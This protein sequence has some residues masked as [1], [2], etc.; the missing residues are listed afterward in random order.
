MTDG[1]L[2]DAALDVLFQVA[3]VGLG[4]L[5]A[6]KRYVR[7]NE[8]LAGLNGLPVADHIGRTP[9][10]ALPKI[11]DAV[12]SVIEHVIETKLPMID[13]ELEPPGGDT[14]ARVSLYPLLE[15]QR[16]IGVL[17]VVDTRP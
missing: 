3:P 16:V 10:E 13:L 14:P 12:E 7:I 6:D 15:D 2:D 1:H 11:G 4:L 8:I 17:G 9:R 5:D